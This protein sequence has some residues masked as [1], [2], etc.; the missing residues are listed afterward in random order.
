SGVLTA[1]DEGRCGRRAS[2]AI[3]RPGIQEHDKQPYE[4]DQCELVEKQ[5]R[6]HGNVPS[7]RCEMGTFYQVSTPRGLSARSRYATLQRSGIAQARCDHWQHIPVAGGTTEGQALV[8]YPHGV[9]QV[10]LGE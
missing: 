4:C 7:Y 2:D 10:P 8:Q 9:L 1:W 5:M 3:T 6:H